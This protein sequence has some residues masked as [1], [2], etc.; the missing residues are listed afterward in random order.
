M[1]QLKRQKLHSA[2]IVII[3]GCSLFSCSVGDDWRKW[4]MQKYFS[5]SF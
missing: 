5:F 2:V 1:Q 4:C 3:T